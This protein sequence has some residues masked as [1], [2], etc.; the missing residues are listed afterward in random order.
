MKLLRNLFKY[1]LLPLIV[2]IIV[3]LVYLSIGFGRLSFKDEFAVEDNYLSFYPEDYEMARDEFRSL[4]TDIAGR[5]EGVET[6]SILVPSR[7]DNDL[8]ID[9]CYI[10]AQKDS[11]NLII[12]S[13]GVHGVE[14]FVGHAAQQL[15]VREFLTP[16]LVENTGV[17]LVHGVNPYGFKYARRVTENNVDMNRNSPSTESLYETVNDGYPQVYDLVNP[18]G[19]ADKSTMGNRF[20]FVTAVNEIRKASMP[21]LRQ[22]VLQG[23]YEYSEGLYFGGKEP[24]PQI[25]SLR[26]LFK[27]YTNPYRKILTLDLHTGYGE[28]G[29]LH[30]FP[31]PLEDEKRE[32][33]ENLFQGY[34]IDWGDSDD[35]YT[36]TGD[37][38]GFIGI[39]NQGKEFYPMLLEYGTLNSQTTMG[40]L[41]SIHVMILE[42][43]GHQHGYAS[44]EDSIR[45]KQDFLEMYNPQSENWRNH[46]MKQT[47]DVFQTIL[48]R[49][50]AE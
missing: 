50:V 14:G 13:S 40:S 33:L 34:T 26:P 25:D 49:F 38:A 48:P 29:K 43:Q 21:V 18:T 42:N 11:I 41:K 23:Q 37:F 10:P 16:D 20:F 2:L 28:R 4:T 1:V 3:A 9:I 39:T 19:E 6:K 15:F 46:V 27:D 32:K 5:F 35:F 22:A 17:L 30:F 12:L 44:A 24:E 31:N 36:V 7:I 45:V 8:T 47:K